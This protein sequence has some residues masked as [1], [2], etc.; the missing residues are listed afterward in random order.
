LIFWETILPETIQK[1]SK[2]EWIKRLCQREIKNINLWINIYTKQDRRVV[3][4]FF[5]PGLPVP[6]T[7]KEECHWYGPVRMDVRILFHCH[8]C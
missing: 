2:K 1:K 3:P 5:L 6:K 4:R 7:K 8:C